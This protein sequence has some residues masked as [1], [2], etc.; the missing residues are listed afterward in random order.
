NHGVNA[1]DPTADNQITN[2]ATAT[3]NEAGPVS[4]SVDTRSEERRVGKEGKSGTS[5]TDTNHDGLTD[6]GDGIHYNIHVA[7]TGDVTL[8]HVTVTDPLTGNPVSAGTQAMG[9]FEV[10]AASYTSPQA[11]VANHGVNAFDPTADNKIT[12]TATAT[13]NEAGPVSSSVDT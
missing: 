9:A 10:L 3:S 12:N 6:A 7:N 4:S 8:T 13:S 1:F 5:V 2:T 11:D